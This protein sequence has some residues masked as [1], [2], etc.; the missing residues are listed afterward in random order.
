[1]SK[2]HPENSVIDQSSAIPLQES[3]DTY[4]KPKDECEI[5]IKGVECKNKATLVC[6]TGVACDAHKACK[7]RVCEKHRSKKA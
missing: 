2:K 1:M 3:L 5:F 4:I 6:W 7:R